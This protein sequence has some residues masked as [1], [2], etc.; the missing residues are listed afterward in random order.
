VWACNR[1]SEIG[2]S[3]QLQLEPGAAVEDVELHLVPGARLD[4]RYVGK[5]SLAHYAV[6][7]RG[8]VIE[9]DGLPAGTSSAVTVP[10]G[11]VEIRWREKNTGMEASQALTFVAGEKRE[12][13][14]DGKP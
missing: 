6:L 14:W 12:L 4:L 3:R 11:A 9:A 1:N 7:V 13:T 2:F 8:Q 10:V 5:D